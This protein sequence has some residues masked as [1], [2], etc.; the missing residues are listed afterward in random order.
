MNKSL[1]KVINFMDGNKW[2]VIAQTIYN[3]ECYKYLIK[4]SDNGKIFSEDFLLVKFYVRDNKK[5]IEKVSE[6]K[7]LEKVM[8]KMLPQIDIIIKNKSM[9]F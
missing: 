9:I 2:F 7:V 3:D 5:F 6:K 8:F 1:Y 4:L